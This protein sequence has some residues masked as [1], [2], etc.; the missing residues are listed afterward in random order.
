MNKNNILTIFILIFIFIFSSCSTFK[1]ENVKY[2][3]NGEYFAEPD[4][5]GDFTIPKNSMKFNILKL[6]E[7]EGI[8][9][10]ITDIKLRIIRD[11]EG[12]FYITGDKFKYIWVFK[13]DESS[14]K[15]KNKIEL[16]KGRTLEDP[17]F[18]EKKPNIKVFLKDKSEFI[19]NKDGIIKSENK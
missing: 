5:N 9:N 16:L 14:L 1:I 8:K 12:Y 18:N 13:T 10:K 3:W 19:I 6:L 15:L 17:K 4:E 7:E 11:D 2:G